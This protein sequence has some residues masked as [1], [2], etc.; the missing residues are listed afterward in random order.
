MGRS[1][2]HG[3][4]LQTKNNPRTLSFSQTK[5]K[6]QTVY[7]GLPCWFC[8]NY[9]QTPELANDSGLYQN[10]DSTRTDLVCIE[11]VALACERKFGIQQGLLIRVS[12]VW[13]MF[14]FQIHSR[15]H[16]IIRTILASHQIKR[17]PNHLRPI[18]LPK[19]DSVPAATGLDAGIEFRSAFGQGEVRRLA[20]ENER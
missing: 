15:T 7:S 8:A 12:A 2:I 10:G 16:E 18:A 17:R 1:R 19:F 4:K 5:D 3:R 13:P 11:H 20:E 6:S 9:V 14:R